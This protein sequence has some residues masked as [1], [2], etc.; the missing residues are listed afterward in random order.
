ME[1][2]GQVLG[3]AEHAAGVALDLLGLVD[4]NIH[5]C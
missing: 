2:L 3:W 1:T 5:S 4:S